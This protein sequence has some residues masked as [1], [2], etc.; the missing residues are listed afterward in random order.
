MRSRMP[1]GT[2]GRPSS[3]RSPFHSGV[4]NNNSSLLACWAW[5]PAVSSTVASKVITNDCFMVSSTGVIA[6]PL[7]LFFVLFPV[8]TATFFHL[9]HFVGEATDL[10]N[11]DRDAVTA[12]QRKRRR[13]HDTSPGHQQDA[14]RKT[15]L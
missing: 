4:R 5:A 15:A 8:L 1:S 13:R 11:R 7:L 12:L 6:T 9:R 2:R 14:P 3:K 10:I